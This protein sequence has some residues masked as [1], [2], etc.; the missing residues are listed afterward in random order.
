MGRGSVPVSPGFPLE[1]CGND[2]HCTIMRLTFSRSTGMR[3]SLSSPARL[4]RNCHFEALRCTQDK[5]RREIFSSYVAENTRSLVARDDKC[6]AIPRC[7]TVSRIRG[8]DKG[9]VS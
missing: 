2:V 5:L 6:E 3:P 4:C 1:A 9:G 7:D 8:D